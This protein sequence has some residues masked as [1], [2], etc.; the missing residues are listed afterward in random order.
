MICVEKSK[1]KDDVKII[2][3]CVFINF[4]VVALF[5]LEVRS[6]LSKLVFNE[7]L[8]SAPVIPSHLNIAS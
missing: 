2:P 3:D 8:E 1:Q 7:R 6:F 4:L 5:G